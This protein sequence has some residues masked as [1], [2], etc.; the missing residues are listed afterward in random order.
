V[1]SEEETAVSAAAGVTGGDVGAVDE[2]AADSA[3]DKEG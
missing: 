1:G 3:E 2:N